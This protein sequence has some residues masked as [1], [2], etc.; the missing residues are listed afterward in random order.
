M[1]R[2]RS[3]PAVLLQK[4][5]VEG[6]ERLGGGFEFAEEAGGGAE[7]RDHGG[8]VGLFEGWAVE[9]VVCAQSAAPG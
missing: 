7:D 8:W 2:Y 9:E 3:P 5:G 1:R 4:L 6:G